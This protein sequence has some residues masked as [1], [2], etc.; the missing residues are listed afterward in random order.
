V[1]GALPAS[2]IDYREALED[3]VRRD[4]AGHRTHR[5]RAL[6]LRWA[7]AA[8]VVAAAALGALSLV[9][10]HGASASVVD[11]AAA[12][13]SSSPGTIVHVDMLGSQ[14]NGDGSVITWR[15]E[16][17]EQQ[18]PPHDG[19][20][21]QTAPDGSIVETAT[22]DGRSEV[23]DAA[24]D[25]IYVAPPVNEKPYAMDDHDIKPGPR[26]GTALLRVGDVRGGHILAT[27]V[28]TTAQAKALRKGTD[29]IALRYRISKG[30]KPKPTVTV[31]S[32]SSVPKPPPSRDDT[33][34]ADP[35]SQDFRGQILA[36][37]R[38]GEAHVVGH[39]TIAGQDTIEIA[40]SDG[41]TTYF[42]D[43]GSYKPVELRTRGTD[44]GTALRFRT[45]ET[46]PAGSNGN[47]LSLTARHPDAQI[48]RD[49][50]HYNA[51]EARLF[52]H[53]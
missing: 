30:A 45:Y 3:A 47:L 52:P 13:V 4:L 10:R 14:T 44:G 31:I 38:S 42:V 25:T 18:S 53:G 37:L 17:W 36:L 32:A 27:A 19:R 29:V 51:A 43:P 40:S 1:N 24:R 41:H 22:A 21:I 12:A 35:N 7:S 33:S 2:L 9:S 49:P 5:R 28:I 34:T 8:A 20:E 23:Y 6:V 11:R 39:R 16:S 50:A 26:P 48:D 46:L 15:Y